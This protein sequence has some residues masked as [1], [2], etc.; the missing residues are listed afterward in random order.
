MDAFITSSA[1]KHGLSDDDIWNCYRNFHLERWDDD[2]ELCWRYG[3][4]L[5]G[6]DLEIAFL[7]RSDDVDVIVH[8]L[9]VAHPPT[10]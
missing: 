5:A 4:D 2:D 6:N 8:A 9:R 10:P 7:T 1:R 3:T